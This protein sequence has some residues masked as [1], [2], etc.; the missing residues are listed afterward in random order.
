MRRRHTVTNISGSLCSAHSHS[1]SYSSFLSPSPSSSS[2]SSSP[3]SASSSSSRLNCMAAFLLTRPTGR[4]HHF[5]VLFSREVATT[6]TTA[7]SSPLFATTLHPLILS[8]SRYYVPP[9]TPLPFSPLHSTPNP[10]PFFRQQFVNCA[11][12]GD[13]AVH[14][15]VV[16]TSLGS[17]R[18]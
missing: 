6:T 11:P 18:M 3:S 8:L 7:Y 5:N 10:S 15:F 12:D 4:S 1:C 2:S 9:P 14:V 13:A 17:C 16:L